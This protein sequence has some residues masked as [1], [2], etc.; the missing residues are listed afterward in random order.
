MTGDDDAVLEL[1]LGKLDGVRQRGGYWM[2]RC[3]AHADRE[4]S[5]SVKR[6]T[7]QPV[8]F[9]CHAHCER[10]AILDALGLTL[11]DVSRPREQQS[12]DGWTP[13]GPGTAVATYR[14]TDAAGK[15]LFGV[16]RTAD[17]KFWQWRPDP[18]KPYGRAWSVKGRTLV[19]YRLPR[20]R[21][22]ID[23]GEPV[24]VAEGEKDVGNLEAAGVTATCNPMGAGKWRDAYSKALAGAAVVI[25]ADNDKPG[26]DHA[27]QVAASLQG[28][29]TSVRVVR[30]L[31][32]K[33]ASDHL[34]AG[35]GIG[36]FADADLA[37]DAPSAP[38]A[39]TAHRHTPPPWAGDQDILGKLLRALRV[40]GLVGE[41]RNAKLTYLAVASQILSDPV[42]LAMKGLS[43]SGKS[44]TVD[45]VLRFFP[46]DALIVMTAMSERALIYM[47]EEFAHRT[48]VL[49]EATALREERE[50]NDSNL[51]AY[52]VRSLLSEG[53]IRYPVTVKE[54]GEMVTR[55]IV[56][57]G[58]TNFIVTTT[59]TSL[60]AENETRMLSL[61]ADDSETQTRAVLKALAA[62]KPREPDLAEWHAYHRWL[63]TVNHAVVIPYAGYL[64]D[65]VPPVAVRL[66]R[67]FRAVLRLIQ[68]HAI[69]HQLTRKIDDAGRIIATEADYLAIRELVADLIADAV[70]A[71]VLPAIRETVGAVETLIAT[72]PDG[73]TVH[74][75][76]VFLGIERSRAQRRLKGARERGYIKNLEDKRGK[77]ARYDL[78]EP[79]PDEVAILPE[80]VCSAQ[81]TPPCTAF[82]EGT[83]GQDGVCGCA[84]TARGIG[85]CTE[86]GGPL[87][88][89]L[90]DAG[91]TDHGENV[92]SYDE[93][94]K[95]ANLKGRP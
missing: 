94:I 66:R 64:A 84:P 14:Y 73:V 61:P 46:E 19:L 6:G 39:V 10:D 95:I 81:C 92:A 1:V 24:Y 53:Q 27:R 2:A 75:V 60:H 32:G 82:C 79:L 35:H 91:Y 20:V 57:E 74:D 31:K 67:D 85:T 71:T 21:A 37:S 76:S 16:C 83:A 44:F 18:S 50:K 54:G 36:D 33:D 5:L 51:T 12:P 48:L 52:I 45:T 93:A 4:A 25:I 42:S 7:E 15:L 26:F 17:K 55:T 63:A 65:A 70:G 8:I 29:A 88:Q 89:A 90:I 87:G 40:C 23:A 59:A 30:A 11:A 80:R 43:S 22:A 56:K 28:I 86:C 62:G 78:D 68:V 41:N 72:R 49:Y 47:K 34:A 13:S 58:P 3:P 9:Y 69:M 38:S 77:P